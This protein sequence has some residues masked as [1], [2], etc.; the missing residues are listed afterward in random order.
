MEM[1]ELLDIDLDQF[2]SYSHLYKYVL[3]HT[4]SQRDFNVAMRVLR[5]RYIYRIPIRWCREERNEITKF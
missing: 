2:P 5:E 1:Q 4:N 3:K